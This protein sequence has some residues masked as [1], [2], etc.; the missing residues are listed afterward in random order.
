M[1]EEI[2]IYNHPGVLVQTLM[3]RQETNVRMIHSVFT[4]FST[5]LLR[6]IF[7]HLFVYFYLRVAILYIYDAVVHAHCWLPPHGALLFPPLCLNETQLS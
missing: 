5:F 4:T 6:W 1:S 7:V 3:I 2:A